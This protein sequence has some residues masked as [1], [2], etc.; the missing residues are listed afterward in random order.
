MNEK[1]LEI[2]VI[3]NGPFGWPGFE[4]ICSLDQLPNACGIYLQTFQYNNGY[5]IYCAGITRRTFIRRLKEHT[6]K[7]MDGKYNVLDVK[8]AQEGKRKVIW[9]GW[10]Y[11]RAHRDKFEKNKTKILLDAIKQLA[12]FR[13]FIAQLSTKER[14]LERFEASI[15]NNLYQE[16]VPFCDIPDKG[17]FLAPRRKS[18]DTIIVKNYCEHQIYCLPELIEI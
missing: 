12:G 15:M 4:S 10:E 18:E 11:E 14:I 5:I 3:W 16:S 6:R 13:I 2:S 17:M 1:S 7:Y 9:K 8:S